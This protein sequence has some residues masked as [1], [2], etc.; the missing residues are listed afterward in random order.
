V[1]IVRA[2]ID[3]V[4]GQLKPGQHAQI[5]LTHSSHKAI[6]VPSDA[7]IRSG[8]GSHVYVQSGRNSFKAQV[9]STGIENFEQVEIREGLA[10][11]DTVAVT[12]AYLLYSEMILKKGTDPMAVHHH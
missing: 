5:F 3:N 2:A 12:G 6:A 4:N 1:T 10:E 7:V 9:V 11:G 8:Q